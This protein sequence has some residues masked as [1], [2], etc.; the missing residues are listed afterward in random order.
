MA[1]QGL[2]G[3]PGMGQW[4]SAQTTLP[5]MPTGMPLSDVY[6]SQFGSDNSAVSARKETSDVE[7]LICLLSSQ[8]RSEPFQTP[9][10][11]SAAATAPWHSTPIAAPQAPPSV[12]PSATTRDGEEE[13]S[14][15]EGG[16]ESGSSEEAHDDSGIHEF[17][18]KLR[19]TPKS[20]LNRQYSVF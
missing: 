8:R 4:P 2:Y 3:M 20:R 7:V 17:K 13:E 14:D 16:D 10:S 15:E 18:P 9:S 19:D 6:S 1:P 5:S 11:A 12:A